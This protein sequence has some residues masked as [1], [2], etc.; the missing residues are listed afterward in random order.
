M[1]ARFDS[2]DP[3]RPDEAERF[4]FEP[5]AGYSNSELASVASMVFAGFAMVTRFTIWGW[6]ALFAGVS[7]V[8]SQKSYTNSTRKDQSMMSGWSSVMFSFTALFSVYAPIL[9]GQ[10][11]KAGGI[12]LGFGK[13][14]IA[15]PQ[16]PVA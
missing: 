7:S 11:K 1:S 5:S 12:P 8:I 4:R 10:A 13:G 9:L 6:L 14:L 16:V 3:K 2:S 15:I